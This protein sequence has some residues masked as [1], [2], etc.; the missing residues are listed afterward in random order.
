[1]EKTTNILL[2]FSLYLLFTF[3][4]MWYHNNGRLQASSDDCVSTTQSEGGGTIL[5]AHFTREKTYST[6]KGYNMNHR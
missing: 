3:L 6:S 4:C 5:Q 1:M 2:D